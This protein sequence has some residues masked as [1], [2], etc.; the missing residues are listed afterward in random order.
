MSV[1]EEIALGE[2]PGGVQPG[3]VAQLLELLVVAG[4]VGV[5]VVSDRPVSW[6]RFSACLPPSYCLAAKRGR[7]SRPG[8]AAPRT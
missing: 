4:H 3:D 2:E 8:R 7:T 5:S 6:F 1:P